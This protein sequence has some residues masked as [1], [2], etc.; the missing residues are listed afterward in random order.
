MD[1]ASVLDTDERICHLGADS[2]LDDVPERGACGAVRP[3]C[4][5]SCG[6]D[7]SGRCGVRVGGSPF[8]EGVGQA[9]KFGVGV[10][11]LAEG[12]LQAMS[13]VVEHLRIPASV[14]DAT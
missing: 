9:G 7:A 13:R 4:G 12:F 3:E 2:R 6:E 14:L 10:S 11:F 1:A 5:S 8:N